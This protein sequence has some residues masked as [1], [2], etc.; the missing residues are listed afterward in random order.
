MLKIIKELMEHEKYS[1][2]QDPEYWKNDEEISLEPIVKYVGKELPKLF[3]SEIVC[4]LYR[5]PNYK[6]FLDYRDLIGLDIKAGFYLDLTDDKV[7]EKGINFSNGFIWG[8]LDIEHYLSAYLK[9]TYWYKLRP[10]KRITVYYVFS[11]PN[12]NLQLRYICGEGS[13]RHRH[14]DGGTSFYTLL[15][16]LL[17]NSIE[18]KTP[19]VFNELDIVIQSPFHY[20]SNKDMLRL[21]L[22]EVSKLIKEE[23]DVE[24]LTELARHRDDI[25]SGPLEKIVNVTEKVIYELIPKEASDQIEAK[26]R[27]DM[28]ELEKLRAYQERLKR[29]VLENTRRLQRHLSTG[30]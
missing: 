29:E 13:I 30:F 21:G 22:M 17:I 7:E 20:L 6:Y 3:D 9:V 8:A 12:E 25:L 1:V 15:L 14:K 5:L 23:K 27:A 4:G 2:V 28:E 11:N 10:E 16:Y 24:K 26:K 19:D 18:V